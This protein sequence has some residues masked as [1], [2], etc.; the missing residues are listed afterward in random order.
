MC[1]LALIV[2]SKGPGMEYWTVPK[3]AQSSYAV[4]VIRCPPHSD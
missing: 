2:V 3:L 4:V 1:S